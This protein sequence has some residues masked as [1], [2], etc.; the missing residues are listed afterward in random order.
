MRHNDVIVEKVINID[1]NSSS[2]TAM[3]SQQSV[4]K[5]STESVDCSRR[6]L[7]ANSCTHRRRRGDGAT[8]IAGQENAGLEND[9]H[10]IKG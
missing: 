8:E 7:A 4:S 6:E 5:L 1:Q 3:E 9:G 10:S 2:Q